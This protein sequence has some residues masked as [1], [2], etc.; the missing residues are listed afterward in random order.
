MGTSRP[1]ASTSSAFSHRWDQRARRP[2]P[3]V[4]SIP[5]A[6]FGP[7]EFLWETAG[8]SQPFS[9]PSNVAIAPDGNI[10]ITDGQHSVFQIFTPD[11]TFIEEWG[12]PGSGEGGFNFL[13]T[14]GDGVG[15][16]AFA[17]D[18]SFY[19][20]DTGNL[21]VQHFD[22]DRAFMVAW[23]ESGN[24]DGQFVYPFDIAV[25]ADGDIFVNDFLRD[26]IQKFDAE[27]QFLLSFGGP[28]SGEGQLADPF[29]FTL[30][31]DG[32]VWVPDSGNGRI[33][34][35]DNDGRFL[36][37]WAGIAELTIPSVVAV[38]DAGRVFVGDILSNRIVVLDDAGNV[39]TSWGGSGSAPGQF[40]IPVGMALDGLGNVYTVEVEGGRLQKFRLLPPLAPETPTP[41]A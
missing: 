11:G 38:D 8:G 24:G 31:A 7:V 32:N 20:I 23:G 10:W 17:P 3:E 29:Y 15:G 22:Q 5:A 16:I 13:A 21:R 36:Y 14:N 28:G 40:L 12:T 33:Q 1:A 30:D 9:Q 2:T 26:D 37:A 35:W 41:V 27:G 6:A 19:V 34:V 4:Y 39:V 25:D 18:G